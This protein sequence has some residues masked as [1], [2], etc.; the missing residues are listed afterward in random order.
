MN[1]AWIRLAQKFLDTLPEGKSGSWNLTAAAMPK[2]LLVCKIRYRGTYTH[3]SIF[4][5]YPI[6]T[7]FGAVTLTACVT[8]QTRYGWNVKGRACNPDLKTNH[9]F[10][11]I[12][13]NFLHYYKQEI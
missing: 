2:V 11:K 8:Y 10:Y 7:E 1:R 3:K 9:R 5:T 6:E 4:F 13:E 12:F